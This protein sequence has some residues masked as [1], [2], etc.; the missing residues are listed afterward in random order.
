MNNLTEIRL[1]ASKVTHVKIKDSFKGINNGWGVKQYKYCEA[2]YFNF[3]WRKYL[4]HEA[5]Y[6]RDGKQKPN[7]LSP[8]YDGEE[9]QK[10]PMYLV[11]DG[12]VYTKAELIIYVG[13]KEIKS[14]YFNNIETA[15]TY[16]NIN[17]QNLN[18]IF[19]K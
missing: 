11:C 7:R 9:V 5:G 18:I 13:A 17:F 12:W 1:D 3:L 10:D 4:E 6:W 2:K 15:K 19:S 16:C 14:L 8:M